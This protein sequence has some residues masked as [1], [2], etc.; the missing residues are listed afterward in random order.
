MRVAASILFLTA[1]LVLAPRPTESGVDVGAAVG[2]GDPINSTTAWKLA[3]TI[4]LRAERVV[5]RHLGV[6][7]MAMGGRSGIKDAAERLGLPSVG[8]DTSGHV[9]FLAG[10]LGLR[11][12]RLGGAV[13]RAYLS[14]DALLAHARTDVHVDT[15]FF[16]L[17][18]DLSIHRTRLTPSPAF[19]F[20]RALKHGAVTGEIRYLRLPQDYGL[21]PREYV[22]FM[23][24]LAT[25]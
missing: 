12:G 18:L 24:G 13:H 16:A 8:Y 21:P 19:V 3:P 7:A 4:Q 1:V 20:E 14:A 25:R 22:T 5:G 2:L 15:P 9:T 23:V 10:G 6:G 17:P 11:V